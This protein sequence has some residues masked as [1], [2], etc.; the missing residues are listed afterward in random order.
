M[1]HATLARPRKFRRQVKIGGVV[2]A[3]GDG[4]TMA[5]T[6]CGIL[7]TH[8]KSAL[9]RQ[10]GRAHATRTSRQVDCVACLAISR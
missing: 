6:R 10:G 1:T 8:Q 4:W 7:Y 9:L 3:Y 5:V 2:H